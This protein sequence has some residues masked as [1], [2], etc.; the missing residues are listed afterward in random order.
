M[1]RVEEKKREKIGCQNQTRWSQ[2]FG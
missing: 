2:R 1:K